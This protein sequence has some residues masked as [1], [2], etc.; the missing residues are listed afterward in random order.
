MK[1]A[2]DESTENTH[3]KHQQISDFWTSYNALVAAT[4]R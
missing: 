1:W 3:R 4:L 2:V